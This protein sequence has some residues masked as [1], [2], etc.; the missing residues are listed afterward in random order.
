MILSQNKAQFNSWFND[1]LW[2][3]QEVIDIV[4]KLMQINSDDN[5]GQT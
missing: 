5:L 1:V 4:A 3:V 2:F